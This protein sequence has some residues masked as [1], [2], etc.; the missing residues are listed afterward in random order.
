[1]AQEDLDVLLSRM[2][3][4]AKAVNAFTS[5]SV[6]QEAFAALVAAFELGRGVLTFVCDRAGR[7]SVARGPLRK[8]KDQNSK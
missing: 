6:Q 8:S 2:D 3:G 1:M 7:I 4:I 5:E